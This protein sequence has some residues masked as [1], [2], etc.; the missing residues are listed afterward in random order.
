MN[1]QY[2]LLAPAKLRDPGA[3]V[4]V[5]GADLLVACEGVGLTPGDRYTFNSI[6]RRAR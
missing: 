3:R 1:D 2:R 4:V 5:E 6:R